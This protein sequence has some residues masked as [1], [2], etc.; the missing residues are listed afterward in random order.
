MQY[1]LLKY[2]QIPVRQAIAIPIDT[3]RGNELS[4]LKMTW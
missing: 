4:D 2:S 1:F 3:G